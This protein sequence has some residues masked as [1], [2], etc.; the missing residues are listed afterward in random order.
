MKIA[1]DDRAARKIFAGSDL[2]LIPS[3]YEPCGLTQMY[4]LRYGAI[5]VVRA[6]G[7]LDDSVE[8]YRPE[9][10]TGTGFKFEE[11]SSEALLEAVSG[12][13]A[14]WRNP[15]DRWILQQN[16]M[17]RDFSWKRSAESYLALYRTLGPA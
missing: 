1:Y 15:Y 6:V 3:R 16:G 9:S 7:G 14:A 8:A 12:A 5:P 11:A 13:L 2:F 17:N 4:S 10:G